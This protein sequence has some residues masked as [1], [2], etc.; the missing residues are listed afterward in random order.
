MST[1]NILITGLVAVAMASAGCA[2]TIPYIS[3]E[4]GA[5]IAATPSP[6]HEFT[7]VAAY[8]DDGLIE[9]SRSLGAA[10]I[11]QLR[12]IKDRVPAI[13]DVRGGHG[14]FAVV[15]LVRDRTTKEPVSPWPD[16]HPSLKVFVER[17]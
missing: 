3:N 8:E 4:L 15:E 6:F 2:T 9:R 12:A 16:S 11:D 7:Y 1:I 13:G 10:L 5:R 17:A 14:L